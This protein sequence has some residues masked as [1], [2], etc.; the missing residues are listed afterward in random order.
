MQG[1][2]PSLARQSDRNDACKQHA[3]YRIYYR[4]YGNTVIVIIIIRKSM[5]VQPVV[6]VA[7][8]CAEWINTDRQLVRYESAG[9]TNAFRVMEDDTT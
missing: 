5:S 9:R 8:Q 7:R 6:T 1:Q 3:L 4:N 2:E